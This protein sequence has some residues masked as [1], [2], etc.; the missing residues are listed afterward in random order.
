MTY[1]NYKKKS[2]ENATAKIDPKNK[3]IPGN[4][5]FLFLDLSEQ[6]CNFIKVR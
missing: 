5:S 2:L 1:I 4:I 3:K 6:F